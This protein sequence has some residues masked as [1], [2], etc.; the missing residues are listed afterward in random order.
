L[1]CRESCESVAYGEASRRW[2]DCS[3]REVSVCT[4]WLREREVEVG[5]HESKG[6]F[7]SRFCTATHDISRSRDVGVVE[8]F[9]VAVERDEI[10]TEVKRPKEVS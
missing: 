9:A 5:D 3:F 6:E 10:A 2:I 4:Q 1:N 8:G 7:S